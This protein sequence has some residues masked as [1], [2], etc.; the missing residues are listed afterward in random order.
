M[1]FI[2]HIVHHFIP[3]RN[4]NH[5]AHALQAPV[6]FIYL[7]FFVIVQFSAPF[8]LKGKGAVLGYAVNI[9]ESNLLNYTNEKRV[10]NGLKPLKLNSALQQAALAK[11][12]YMFA[13]DFW[14]HNAPDGTT[15]WKFIEDAGYNYIFAGENLAK[16]FEDSKS[17]VDAWM[18]SPTHSANILQEKYQDIGFAVLNGVLKGEETTLVVQMFGTSVSSSSQSSAQTPPSQVSGATEEKMPIKLAPPEAQRIKIETATGNSI[19][20]FIFTKEFS[21]LFI[22]FLMILLAIDGFFIWNKKII[23]ISSHG[24]AHM[25]F[26]VFSLLAVLFLQ[27]GKIL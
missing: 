2:D 21:L 27:S 8:I 3:H 4:N 20:N 13:N 18:A 17:V 23:R 22:G 14:A 12:K 9:E 16:D 5:K 19:S 10:E 1:R 15:P 25:L 11:A 7:L 6:L 24:S 26:L